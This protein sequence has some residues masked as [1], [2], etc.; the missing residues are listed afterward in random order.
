MVSDPVIYGRVNV[1]LAPR[2]VLRAVPGMDPALVE[3]ILGAGGPSAA[4]DARAAT[5]RGWSR[6][7][8]SIG[9]G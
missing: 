8:W 2:E 7:A 9:S 6:K 1:N 4:S 3:Q 5:P